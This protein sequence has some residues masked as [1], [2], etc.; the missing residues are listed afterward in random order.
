VS[1]ADFDEFLQRHVGLS[2]IFT[3]SAPISRRELFR[4]RIDQVLQVTSA[5]IEPGRHVVL[6]GERG[7]GKTSLANL[8]TE[9]LHVPTNGGPPQTVRFNCN[10][11]DGFR[12]IWHKAFRELHVEPPSSWSERSPDPDDVRWAL[13]ELQPPR[14]IVI[15]EFDRVEDD[16]TLSLMADTIKSLSDHNVATKLVIVGVADSLDQLMGQHESVQ[17][18]VE[19]VLMPR[20]EETE[21]YEIID[22]GLADVEMTIEPGARRQ[23]AR[24]AEG[25]PTYVHLL[26]LHAAR[27]AVHGH[28]VTVEA[29]D[30]EA[31]VNRVVARHSLLREYQRAVDS[32]YPNNLFSRVLAACALAEK[33]RLGYFTAGAVREPMS[34]IMGRQYDIPAFAPHLNAFTELDRGAVLKKEGVPRRY[35]YRFRNPL[36]QP[37]AILAAI[38]AGSI[39]EDY[40][41][42]LYG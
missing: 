11:Q 15:D 33:N 2:A 24:L 40:K 26:A 39:P 41:T 25:L 1:P 29:R 37:F 9:F 36:L 12:S 27:E 35:M 18:A 38:A 28:R 34:R 5:V 42:E 3:P 10:T 21:A 23:V 17:R 6:Y 31:A 14:I 22:N 20:M 7:V 32:P 19:E 4:G 16:E 8:L 30:V 13:G